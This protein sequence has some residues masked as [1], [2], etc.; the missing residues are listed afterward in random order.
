MYS[1][2]PR[3][4]LQPSQRVTF[5]ASSVAGS[6]HHSSSSTRRST[7]TSTTAS[8]YRSSPGASR[9][10]MTLGPS[11]QRPN[12]GPSM[13][14]QT[15]VGPS[16]NILT[17]RP[18]HTTGAMIPF[19]P[20]VPAPSLT[21]FASTNMQTLPGPRP[22]MSHPPIGTVVFF[23]RIMLSLLPKEMVECPAGFSWTRVEGGYRC[24]G[25]MHWISDSDMD[26]YQLCPEAG[27]WY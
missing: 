9:N 11:Q 15:L 8:Q 13:Y 23:P 12:T 25:G 3:G 17:Q 19:A 1:R 6:N 4:P 7:R 14:S 5:G 20:P 21:S 26:K 10:Y 18:P 16:R 2:D 24:I 27:A 22:L